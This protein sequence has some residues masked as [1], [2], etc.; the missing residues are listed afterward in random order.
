[1][2]TEFSVEN[3]LQIFWEGHIFFTLLTRVKWWKMGQIFIVFSEYLN[4]NETCL[5]FLYVVKTQL[6]HWWYALNEINFILF[7]VSC[8]DLTLFASMCSLVHQIPNWFSCEIKAINE[9]IILEA[10]PSLIIRTANAIFWISLGK[11]RGY[12]LKILFLGVKFFC[13]VQHLFEIEFQLIQL[14]QTIII[15]IFSIGCLIELKFCEVS[16]ISFSNRCWMFQLF[17]LKNKKGLFLKKNILSPLTIS[18]LN[19]FVYWPNFQWSFWLEVPTLIIKSSIQCA[20]ADFL[21]ALLLLT[22]EQACAPVLG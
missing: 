7:F 8:F 13:F 19:F 1:M 16:W 11:V 9:N 2:D 5:L 22:L 17:I 12:C 6:W 14:I 21:S 4:F 20:T 15:F 10:K 18:K 3:E